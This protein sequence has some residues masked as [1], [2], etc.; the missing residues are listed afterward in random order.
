LAAMDS[1]C[2]MIEPYIYD[3]RSE[4]RELVNTCR[5]YSE[6]SGGDLGASMSLVGKLKNKLVKENTRDWALYLDKVMQS[7]VCVD[8]SSGNLK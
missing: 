2:S 1:F 8:G 6:A 7:L 5:G 3:N 4:D